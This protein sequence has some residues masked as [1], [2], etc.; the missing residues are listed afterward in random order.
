MAAWGLW[1]GG[2]GVL[3]WGQRTNEFGWGGE[4][5]VVALCQPLPQQLAVDSRALHGCWQAFWELPATPASGTRFPVAEQEH[6]H[7]CPGCLLGWG[8]AVLTL[9]GWRCIFRFV[10]W[11]VYLS[12][13]VP[14]NIASAGACISP[15]S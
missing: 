9:L 5:A 6:V 1:A 14:Q 7:V 8:F 11:D 13:K 2:F 4:G 10:Y 15:I 12:Q 3:Y